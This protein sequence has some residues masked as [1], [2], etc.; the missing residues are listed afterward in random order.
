MSANSGWIAW[1][2]DTIGVDQGNA[3]MAGS[4]F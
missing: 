2:Q 3:V 4:N 1:M